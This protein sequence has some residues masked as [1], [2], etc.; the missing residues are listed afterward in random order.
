MTWFRTAPVPAQAP[1]AIGRLGIG[2]VQFGQA[3]GVS[4]TQGQV[5]RAEVKL[6][7]ELAARTERRRAGYSRQLWGSGSRVWAATT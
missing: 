5:P 1:R 7:L 2:T 3:Y 6:I 4:N